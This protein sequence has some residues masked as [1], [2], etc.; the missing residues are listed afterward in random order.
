MDCGLLEP[1]RTADI[2]QQSAILL[3]SVIPEED[4]HRVLERCVW[5]LIG[6]E[7]GGRIAVMKIREFG[8]NRTSQIT[9]LARI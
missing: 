2:Q 6:G 3:C 9:G 7:R 1:S 5:R 8:N 4:L